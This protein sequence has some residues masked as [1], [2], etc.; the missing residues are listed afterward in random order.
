MLAVLTVLE[1]GVAG[2]MEDAVEEAGVDLAA[3]TP[4]LTR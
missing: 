3:L 2:E 1:V 4:P